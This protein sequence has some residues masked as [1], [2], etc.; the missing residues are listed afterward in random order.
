M[1]LSNHLI[2]YGRVPDDVLAPLLDQVS[3]IPSEAWMFRGDPE[4]YKTKAIRKHLPPAADV[5][6]AWVADHLLKPGTFNRVVLSCVPA[7]EQILSHT[8]NFGLEVRS[9]SIHGHLPLVTD[10]RIVL[11]FAQQ[12]DERHLAKGHVYRMDESQE[13]Y[14][15]NPTTLD[16]IH[17]LFAFWP[18]DR[19]ILELLQPREVSYG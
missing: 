3:R 8:D 4:S 18:H 17:L 5:V 12:H 2:E 14:V 19:N 15:K 7:G 6:L 16:R 1:R 11:G 13:H 9:Q 10:E